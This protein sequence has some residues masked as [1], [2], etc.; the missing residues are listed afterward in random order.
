M[1][2]PSPGSL[3]VS[4]EPWALGGL[5]LAP[6]RPASPLFLRHRVG[7]SRTGAEAEG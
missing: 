7:L 6:S 4:L 1:G 3:G 2:H 5:F